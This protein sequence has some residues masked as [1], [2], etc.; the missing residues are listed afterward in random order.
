MFNIKIVQEEIP[1]LEIV[2]YPDFTFEKINN[3][4]VIFENKNFFKEFYIKIC[5]STFKHIFKYFMENDVTFS[6]QIRRNES[7]KKKNTS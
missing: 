2:F 1:Y 5:A 7:V 4:S 6:M 3:T